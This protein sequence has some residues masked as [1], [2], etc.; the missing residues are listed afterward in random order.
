MQ[1][2][3]FSKQNRGRISLSVADWQLP[4]MRKQRPRGSRPMSKVICCRRGAE[5]TRP[6]CEARTGRS[7][8]LDKLDNQKMLDCPFGRA[9]RKAP[10]ARP[11]RSEG[12]APML[13]ASR[14]IELVEI[15]HFMPEDEVLLLG[16]LCWAAVQ[17]SI[18]FVSSIEEKET[19]FAVCTQDIPARIVSPFPSLRCV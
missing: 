5:K 4:G 6:V 19:V 8:C 16:T 7:Q 15:D 9:A 18:N 14:W 2:E 12:T 11:K 10:A 17:K 13:M 3:S 1:K